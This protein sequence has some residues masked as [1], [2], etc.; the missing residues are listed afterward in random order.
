MRAIVVGSDGSPNS[1]L[2]VKQ[3]SQIAKGSGATLHLVAAYPD[4]PT[5][6]ETIASG[7]TRER[8]D[9]REVAESV[10]ARVAS[11]PALEGLDVETH[12]SVGD[13][14][15]VILDLADEVNADLIVVGARGLTGLERFLLGSVSS[16]LTHNAKRSLMVVRED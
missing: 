15:R 10:L 9:L 2:A 11:D 12:A 13:P 14:A 8:I 1:N 16:K 5:F 6:G 4:D 7:A 3:A